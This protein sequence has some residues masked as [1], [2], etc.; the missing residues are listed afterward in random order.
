VPIDR[1][2]PADDPDPPYP[3]VGP[4]PADSLR[5]PD[6]APPGD[7]AGREAVHHA[8]RAL[9]DQAYAAHQDGL[10]GSAP[11]DRASAWIEA[12]PALRAAWREHRD[13]YS[14]RERATPQTHSDDS[15]SS[16]DARRLTP[17]QHAEATRAC[18]DIRDEG[19][20]VILPQMRRVEAADPDRRLTGLEHMLK[21]ADRLKEKIAQRLRYHPDLPPRE[22][23]GRVPDAVRFTLEYSETHYSDGVLADVERL[24]GAGYELLKLKNLWSKDQYKGVNSQW[25]RPES[26]LRFE[27]QFHT[28]ESQQAKELTHEAYERLRDPLT[29]K[30]E[31]SAL[32]T[33][34][35]RV[36]ALIRIPPGVST[37]E[38]YPPEKRDG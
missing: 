36:N 24:K 8:Y 21:G 13:L 6:P 7:R 14:E 22:A 30:A 33:Y 26:G 3:P 5:T 23:A 38:D 16:G 15:W 27:V 32:E 20:R 11:A 10:R 12:L 25:R 34:Q 29:S 4:R 1:T 19:E 2:D 35:Q 17:G 18:A 31:E 37:I 28:Q 9:A